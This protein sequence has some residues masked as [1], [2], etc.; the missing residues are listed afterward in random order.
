VG[1]ISATAADAAKF[2]TMFL[3]NGEYNGVR[4]LGEASTVTMQTE[5]HR[6]ARTM[7]P[8]NYGIIESNPLGVRMIGHGGDTMYFHTQLALFP[9]HDLGLFVSYNSQRGAEARRAFI[10]QFVKRYFA[11]EEPSRP[12]PPQGFEDRAARYTGAYRANR[13][14]HKSLA[15][16]ASAFTPVNVVYDGNGALKVSFLGDRRW[17]EVET[18]TFQ[19]ENS[20]NRI[21]FIENEYGNITHFALAGIP[22]VAYERIGPWA[23]PSVHIAVFLVALGLCLLAFVSWPL[24][25]FIRRRHDVII[26]RPLAIPI[27]ARVLGWLTAASV[28]AFAVMSIGSLQ[29]RNE[30]AFGVP[31]GFGVLLSI[32]LAIAILAFAMAGM[33]IHLWARGHGGVVWRTAYTVLTVAVLIVVCQAFYWNLTILQNLRFF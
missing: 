27:K 18:N 9:E 23:K 20:A 12:T 16:L 6:M 28:I 21:V 31:A 29:N 32:P 8:M 15:K 2:M 19:D 10:S 30:V 14:S 7:V 17:I 25:A 13:F 33:T 24:A 3:Q 1:G 11:P 4:V 26:S 22:I 5:L